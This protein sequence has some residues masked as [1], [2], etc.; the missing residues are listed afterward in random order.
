MK[1][2]RS[3]LLLAWVFAA[4]IGGAQAP[5]T[6]LSQPEPQTV[7][8]GGTA[9]FTVVAQSDEPLR[10]LWQLTGRGMAGQTNPILVLSNVTA[11]NAG[12]YTVRITNS[13]TTITSTV[14]RLTVLLPPTL[15]AEPADMA[16]AYG[17]TGRLA[18]KATGTTPLAYR[19]L[20]NGE[21]LDGPA[22][23]ILTLAAT[24][25]AAFGAYQVIVTND[26]GAVTSRLAR[27][28]LLTNVVEFATNMLRAS[29]LQGTL[30]LPVRRTGSTNAITIGVR[31]V[32]GTAVLNRDYRE[33]TPA[34]LGNFD[35]EAESSLRLLDDALPESDRTLTLELETGDAPDVVLGPR[36]RLVVTV[37]DNDT[38]AEGGFGFDGTI[39]TLQALHDGGILVAG[40]FETVHGA[41]RPHLARL[42][43]D[44]RLDATF[45]PPGFVETNDLTG[46]WPLEDGGVLVR[47]RFAFDGVG[48]RLLRKLDSQGTF[49][50]NGPLLDGFYPNGYPENI[51]V[52][53]QVVEEGAGRIL[54]AGI[55]LGQG[56]FTTAEATQ[57]Y[58]L[59]RFLPDGRRDPTLGGHLA[60]ADLRTQALDVTTTR[61]E[62]IVIVGAFAN[63]A[64]HSNRGRIVKLTRDGSVHPKFR[65]GEGFDSAPNRVIED[66]RGRLLIAG[67]F[68]LFDGAPAPGLL[69]LLPT[70]ERDSTFA[71]D[72]QGSNLTQILSITD[73]RSLVRTRTGEVHLLSE[74]GAD[75]ATLATEATAMEW[76][77]PGELLVGT[78]TAPRLVTRTLAAFP[79]AA[80]E[81]THSSLVVEESA[82]AVSLGIRRLGPDAKPLDARV[83]FV[84]ET[85]VAGVDFA[86]TDQV[87]TFPAGQSFA[88]VRLPLTAQ[89]TSPNDDRTLRAELLDG[90]GTPLPGS[91]RQCRVTL[92]DDDTGFLAEL[93]LASPGFYDA[94]AQVVLSRRVEVFQ[95]RVATT[96]DQTVHHD[97]GYAWPPGATYDQFAMIWTAVL[98]PEVSGD[99]EFQ[100]FSDDGARLW[101]N[102]Q[103]V[104]AEWNDA[105]TNLYTR[106]I[107]LS[108]GQTYALS[109]HFFENTGIAACHLLWRPPGAAEFTSIP[110]RVLRPAKPRGTLPTLAVRGGP[111]LGPDPADGTIP[112][113]FQIE[114][115]TE[116][117]RPIHIESSTN[118]L[119][120]KYVA[121]AVSAVDGQS[122][123]F[124]VLPTSAR[125]PFGA[126]L[127]AVSIDGQ[128]VTNTIPL[129][130]A[131]RISAP[132]Q[133]LVGSLTNQ[134]DLTANANGWPTQTF[135]WLKDGVAYASGPTLTLTGRQRDAGGSYRIIADAPQ[136]RV[137][138]EPFALQ[139]LSPPQLVQPLGP[140]QF[141]VG[142]QVMLEPGIRG[143]GTL[144]YRW[145]RG[146]NALPLTNVATL[147]LPSVQLTHAGS[148]RVVVA[149]EAGSLTNG[150][151]ELTVR[152]PVGF[153]RGPTS[154]TLDTAN[155]RPLQLDAEVVGNG[156][157]RYQWRLNGAD[158]PGATNP[159]LTIS[160]PTLAQAGRYT[161]VAMDDV[162][163]VTSP[164]AEIRPDFPPLDGADAFAAAVTLTTT[165]GALVGDS[166]LA[167]REPGEPL[168]AGKPGGH[169]VVYRW[170]AP[171]EG[172][173]T[174]RT[175]GSSFDT[176]LAAY[177]GSGIGDLVE[178]ASNDDVPATRGF[179]SEITFPTS[180]G[181]AFFIVVDGY[182]GSAGH[183]ALSWE[184]TTP[185]NPAPRLLE[186][187]ATQT[188]SAGARVELRIRTENADTITW[189][190]N[191]EILPGATAERLVLEAATA[192][193]VGTYVAVVR[194]GGRT[195][196]SHPALI[197]L[198]TQPR[199]HSYDKPEEF[200][201]SPGGSGPSLQH[202]RNPSGPGGAPALLVSP[203]APVSQVFNTRGYTTQE[204]EANHCVTLVYRTGWLPLSTTQDGYLGVQMVSA[205]FP[206][207]LTLYAGEDL[208]TPLA[209]S[210][211]G[212]IVFPNALKNRLYW[213]A[214][215]S[216]EDTGGLGELRV[217]TGT[218]PPSI[219]SAPAAL[220]VP[221]GTPLHLDAPALPGLLPPP[222]YLWRHDGNEIAGATNAT[223]DLPQSA[224]NDAG[225]YTVVVDN[226]LGWAEYAVAQVEIR[227]PLEL[228]WSTDNQ[229]L[230]FGLRGD[231]GQRV[232]VER[233][234]PNLEW[235]TTGELWL[236]ATPV[237]YVDSQTPP[238]RSALYRGREVP[239]TA[240]QSLTFSD[241]TE[242]W[243]IQGGRLGRRFAVYEAFG[244]GART[245]VATN[246]IQ[247]LPYLHLTPSQPPRQVTAELLPQQ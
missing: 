54:V 157:I 185:A 156:P 212:T 226:S 133:R 209:C 181:T 34:R 14:A 85:A 132:T 172:A 37:T 87:V 228:Q 98:V 66:T 129:P 23:R 131:A 60:D 227:Q 30:P 230:T 190:F 111:A 77:P 146:T 246:L 35:A 90:N 237:P 49:D 117:G 88:T 13:R 211:G 107:R 67:S 167:T 238:E 116:A 179:A 166:S 58:P 130:L 71:P 76:L 48:S 239:L 69:R 29:E 225:V 39:T 214:F 143:E 44:L 236:A 196:Y 197:E 231:P 50:P 103:L 244:D 188:V 171:S 153:G 104:V 99:Y 28:S 1:L 2:L 168:P 81:F 31:V 169:S 200:A 5:I 141:Q 83:R 80:I 126:V 175:L 158:V 40:N 215:G 123:T 19:W 235:Q 108:A 217:F 10:Y 187:P 134:L 78:D 207:L 137:I 89:N 232:A 234:N 70:G 205:D 102:D 159:V 100:T 93:F 20:R 128:A 229:G 210:A 147:T 86:S 233:A 194:G 242:G 45:A 155:P 96:T 113:P 203:G 136:G 4:R 245:P 218:P 206:A 59:L 91:R 199:G 105:V 72:L 224:V 150:P 47:S 189:L 219:D 6:I 106:P 16:M 165:T 162:T 62:G 18:V 12:N 151:G 92:E 84:A 208:H 65:T 138:S 183:F 139:V 145:F 160:N 55:F 38:A 61:D 148:Y 41:R 68:T 163:T 240:T 11:A 22:D 32:S 53:R 82:T 25:L 115:S 192:A 124:S 36:S 94:D 152:V 57:N 33:P 9:R 15:T 182:G 8:L 79:E 198:G 64:T 109:L 127:R 120:W 180:A 42:N 220:T 201:D 75:L 101:L 46:L 186:H 51:S 63:S 193:Q 125:V 170:I 223:W 144:R 26:Y 95:Q 74:T 184:F 21:L 178:V 177:R 110:R 191:D 142:D 119:D 149:N 154:A 176:L 202:R 174:F 112:S 17:S 24:N 73:G 247:P 221:V 135:T 97:W 213:L 43:R 222:N 118:G 27:V 173:V 216:T 241:G 52:L 243:S 161:L 204:G 122:N 56:P 121:E 7:A 164:S 140:W 3:L 195:V 114:Y